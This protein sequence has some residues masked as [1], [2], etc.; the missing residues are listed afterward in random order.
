M[1][2]SA[3]IKGATAREESRHP[4]RKI[5]L[6]LGERSFLTAHQ[7]LMESPFCTG[8]EIGRQE[9]FALCIWENRGA[10]VASLANHV[11]PV[12]NEPLLAGQI[13][14]NLRNDGDFAGSR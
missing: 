3:A 13:E 8:L 11:A 12:G 4:F 10:L 1:A 6:D 2:S 9:E 5:G 14:A 7:H